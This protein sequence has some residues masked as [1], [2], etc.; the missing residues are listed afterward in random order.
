MKRYKLLIYGTGNY[1]RILRDNLDENKA[2]ITAYIETFPDKEMYMGRPVLNK[3]MVNMC[4][5]DLLII[6]A[7]A[8]NEILQQLENID[9]RK[10]IRMTWEAFI[11]NEIGTTE[12]LMRAFYCLK[13]NG[14]L[15]RLLNKYLCDQLD[16]SCVDLNDAFYWTNKLDYIAKCMLFQN[17][18]YSKYEMDRFINLS[19]KYYKNDGDGILLDCGCNIGTTSI[20]MTHQN[21]DLKV[22]AYEP[23]PK[24][25]KLSVYNAI[26]NGVEENIKV[27]SKGLS[28]K[29]ETFCM[30]M[31]EDNSGANKVILNGDSERTISVE[32]TDIDSFLAESSIAAE[33]ISYIWMDVEGFEGYVLAGMK[34]LLGEKRI[35]LFTEFNKQ[36]LLEHDCYDLFLSEVKNNY[37]KFIEVNAFVDEKELSVDEIEG[38]ERST[39]LFLIA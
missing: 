34:K 11:S 22:I 19:K 14:R 16:I 23:I 9:K 12:S 20:Y 6:A 39:N 36:L 28:N 38:I 4:N 1:C 25:I 21:I 35:P 26:V 37:T 32:A 33:R 5:Y 27:I 24:N 29:K 30:Q 10:I 18:V 3:D 13:K 17:T 2:E 7:S 8:D 31:A 15:W